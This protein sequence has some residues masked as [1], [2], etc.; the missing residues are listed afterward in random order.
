MPNLA[1]SILSSF[2]TDLLAAGG[3]TAEEAAIVGPSLANANTCDK[4]TA[5]PFG[6][7]CK[8]GHCA[9]DDHGKSYNVFPNSHIC[10]TGNGYPGEGVEDRKRNAAQQTQLGIA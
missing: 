1:P 8:H 4:Q 7:C 3:M 9:P 6:C 10:P 2:A 5:E